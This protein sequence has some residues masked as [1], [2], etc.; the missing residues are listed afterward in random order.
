MSYLRKNTNP[1]RRM[2]ERRQIWRPII[3]PPSND[4]NYLCSVQTDE[5]PVVRTLEYRSG[6]WWDEDTHHV[7]YAWDYLPPPAELAEFAE[8][9]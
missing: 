3:Q 8:Q 4:G 5:G 1:D 9:L 7:P 6:K 2:G